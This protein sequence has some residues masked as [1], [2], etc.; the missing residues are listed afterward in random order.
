[1]TRRQSGSAVSNDKW[2]N[3]GQENA[4]CGAITAHRSI[5]DRV[6]P[7]T[8]DCILYLIHRGDRPVR[9]T[10]PRRWPR[11]GAAERGPLMSDDDIWLG[12]HP[13]G[14]GLVSSGCVVP[15]IEIPRIASAP[16]AGEVVVGAAMNLY[17][18]MN[19]KRST[20]PRAARLGTATPP[21][22][23]GSRRRPP[24]RGRARPASGRA[25]ER[26]S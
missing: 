23:G 1:M 8:A 25:D 6:E 14:R 4:Q 13:I 22:R 17:L 20:T 21:G 12:Y 5:D 7:G 16:M 9:Y 2:M 15:R 18:D 26:G 24:E 10:Q 19:R 11:L 3:S